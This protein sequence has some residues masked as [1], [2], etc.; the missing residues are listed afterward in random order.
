MEGKDNSCVVWGRGGHFTT[1]G[2][3]EG[4]FWGLH[5]G[6]V[7]NEVY[8]TTS[9]TNNNW[10]TV[11]ASCMIIF[12]FRWLNMDNYVPSFKIKC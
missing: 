11:T 5:N 8:T 9:T 10:P 7:C 2:E 1:H 4:W 12:L 6:G 3:G